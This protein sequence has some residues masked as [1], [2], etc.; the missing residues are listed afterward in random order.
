VEYE[1]LRI[2]SGTAHPALA[3]AIAAELDIPVSEVL[4]ARF[5]DGEIRV[6]IQ[7]SMRGMDVFVIQPTSTPANEHLMELLVILDALRRASTERINVVIPYYG[8][9]RQDKKIKP[10]EPVTAKLIADLITHVGADRILAVDLHAGQI[11]GFFNI[12]V[13]HLYGGPLIANYLI[14]Q[15][16]Y[17][18]DV[19]VVS[20]DVGGVAR[21]QVLA[22]LL[23][24][25][26]AIT[27]KR[28]PEPNKAEITQIIG[29]VSGRVA[30]MIDDMIDTGG[31]I[32]AGA[33]AMM[34]MGA[35]KIYACCTHAVLSGSACEWLQNSPIEE[36][37]VTDTI[38][39][40]KEK[41]IKKLRVLS[42]AGL[43]ADAIDR[44][45]RDASVSEL[46]VPYL[47]GR[48]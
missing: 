39:I 7:E 2:L 29:D 30:V 18:K 25:S 41:R 10:R 26:L 8:Y 6:Q 38:P 15:K 12:P 22:D 27:V 24:S 3:Q 35:K 5:S 45:H 44:I 1:K 33:E 36:V 42:V 48:S 31:T 17:D 37:I 21:A 4:I 13:D 20:P 40:P 28:R 23:D 19:V 11:Q 43:L 46:F 32:C 9:A 16:I 47:S 14:K 34:Q